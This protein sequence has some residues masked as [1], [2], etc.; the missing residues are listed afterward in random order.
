[1]EKLPGSLFL[2]DPTDSRGPLFICIISDDS[3]SLP[4]QYFFRALK[5]YAFAADSLTQEEKSLKYELVFLWKV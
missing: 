4:R 5:T 3:L 1:M 2:G